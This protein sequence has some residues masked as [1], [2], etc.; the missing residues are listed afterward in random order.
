MEQRMPS[1]ET[2][3]AMHPDHSKHVLVQ[4]AGLSEFDGVD[5]AGRLIAADDQG[6]ISGSLLPFSEKPDIADNEMDAASVPALTEDNTGTVWRWFSINR[7]VEWVES[8]IVDIVCP[9]GTVRFELGFSATDR[10]LPLDGREIGASASGAA[11]AGLEYQALYKYLWQNIPA[12]NLI[13]ATATGVLTVK[14][15][16]FESDWNIGKRV[17]LPYPAGRVFMMAGNGVGLNPRKVADTGG[18]ERIQLTELN[19]PAHSHVTATAQAGASENIKIMTGVDVTVDIT[20]TANTAVGGAVQVAVSASNV[21][22]HS[23]NATVSVGQGGGGV[24]SHGI[25]SATGGDATHTHTGTV[26]GSSD[27]LEIAAASANLPAVTTEATLPQHTHS[28]VASVAGL[29]PGVGHTHSATITNKLSASTTVVSK[30]VVKVVPKTADK[31][32]FSVSTGNT[33]TQ[34]AGNG[35]M[36]DSMPPFFAVNAY[37]RY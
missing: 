32:I 5:G 24:H 23:H 19:M 34:A 35:A 1:T 14:G 17:R 26:T 2:Y 6:F 13:L 37:I 3:L 10:W 7:I 15:E 27:T 12:D 11:L 20:N 18:V 8:K 4:R 9:V 21:E 22:A 36:Y 29:I 31:S 33:R 25:S 30:P 16:S 28:S